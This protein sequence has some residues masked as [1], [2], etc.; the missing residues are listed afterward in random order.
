MSI[1]DNLEAV[2]NRIAAAARRSGRTP[3]QVRL[4]AVTKYQ[5]LSA[6]EELYAL[7]VRDFGESRTQ[8]AGEKLAGWSRPGVTLHMIGH[9]QRN[10]V[11]QAVRLFDFI[12]SVDS[13]RLAQDIDRQCHASQRSM[14]VL[15]EINISGEEAK[16]GFQPSEAFEAVEEIGRLE[17]IRLHGLMAMAPMVPE[18][19][20]ARPYFQRLRELSDRLQL[21]LPQLTLH[22]L[23]MGMTDDF[24]IAVEEGATMVRVGRA[25]FV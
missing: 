4:V 8:E 3:D 15:A 12:Q 25:L 9:L 19:E 24:E 10:K 5:P 16:H 7:G 13:V 1:A 23:S 2:R 17:N 11:R 20:A 22:E 18:A 6:V 14:P 21:D